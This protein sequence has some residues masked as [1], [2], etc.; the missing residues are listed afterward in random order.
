MEEV[1]VNECKRLVYIVCVCVIKKKINNL[2]LNV[3]P[4]TTKQQLTMI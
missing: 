4:A 3:A 1:A 2:G